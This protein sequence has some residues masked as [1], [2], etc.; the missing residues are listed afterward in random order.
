VL[1]PTNQEAHLYLIFYVLLSHT[2]YVHIISFGFFFKLISF[3]ERK[4]YRRKL[5]PVY[6]NEKENWGVLTNKEIQAIAKN[7][8]NSQKV[9][10]NCFW[11][12]QRIE[13]NSILKRI[14]FKDL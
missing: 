6:D 13:E 1:I 4:V 14:L 11:H 10:F 2:F 9:T 5:A 3:I 7:H 12:A 8:C